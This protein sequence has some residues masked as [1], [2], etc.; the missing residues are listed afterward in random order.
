M[1]D[2]NKIRKDFPMYDL[3]NSQFEGKPL[4]YLDNAATT[5]KPYCVIESINHYYNDI[6]ANT[7]RGDYS[8]AHAADVAFEEARKTVASFI[9][10]DSEC[11]CFTS[12]DSMGLNEIAYGLIPLL[13]EDDEIVL[14]FNEHASNVLP[15][16]QVAKITKAKIVYVPLNEKGYVTLDNLKKV[17]NSHTKVVS[18]ASV[19]NVL[20]YP[21]D[22]KA[23]AKIA[24]SVGAL[25]VDDGAQSVPHKKYDVKD[26]DVDFLCF[27]AHKMCGPTGIG[28]MYGKKE[29]LE[30]L[31]PLFYGGEMNARFHSDGYLSLD[32]IPYRF[33]SGTQNIA[34]VIG[35]AKACEYLDSIGFDEIQKHEQKLK[36]L[37]VE[38]L[39]KNGNCDIYNEDSESGLVTFNI[40]NVFSQDAASYLSDKGVFIRTGT[41]CAKLLPEYLNVETTARASFYI[42]ND[43][44]DVLA[45]V[46]ACKHAEDFL[47]VFFN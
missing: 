17:V 16:F 45:F 31:T 25:Y 42:Y 24:H 18:L 36:K 8:L 4:H 27:S 35:F 11:L 7:R 1:I 5:F 43:E 23:L 19:S 12:G 6:T 10:A 15:W 9:N 26:L 2:V 34:G 47:D 41:H 21:L 28:A 40:H 20:G 13:H 30:K 37:A 14:S 29:A 38:G 33:E 46:E 3:H 22:V 44:E 39:K 32:D